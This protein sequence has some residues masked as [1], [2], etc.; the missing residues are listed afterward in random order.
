MVLLVERAL[1]IGRYDR[2]GGSQFGVRFSIS[3]A[4][5]KKPPARKMKPARGRGGRG[6]PAGT[7]AAQRRS[8][9]FRTGSSSPPLR[10]EAPGDGHRHQQG[11]FVGA[12]LADKK[13]CPPGGTPVCP[14]GGWAHRHLR[15]HYSTI[16]K[17]IEFSHLELTSE[18]SDLSC[19]SVNWM[20]AHTPA[21]NNRTSG[22]Y[23]RC[24]TEPART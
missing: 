16:C 10:V 13:T 20:T 24:R 22:G 11:G 6:R 12:V 14:A 5:L 21:V 18:T 9:R 23:T 4:M 7:G 8:R 1:A 17:K 3:V 2:R 19:Y 15:F